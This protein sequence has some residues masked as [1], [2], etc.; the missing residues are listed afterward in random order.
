MALRL[1]SC[2]VKIAPVQSLPG[3]VDPS[4]AV[5]KKCSIAVEKKLKSKC[6]GSSTVDEK[7]LI[8]P[9]NISYLPVQMVSNKMTDFDSLLRNSVNHPCWAKIIDSDVIC[10][11]VPPTSVGS[12]VFCSPTKLSLSSDA[13][14]S[15][16][17]NSDSKSMDDRPSEE[18]LEIV[19][20]ILSKQMPNL[21]TEMIDYTVYRHDL[22]FENN[23]KGYR[24]VGILP[25]VKHLALVRLIGHLRF[26]YVKLELLKITRHPE[27]GTVKARWRIRGISGLKVMFMFWKIK[28]WKIKDTINNLDSWYDGFSTFHVGSDGKIFKHVVDKVMPENEENEKTTNTLGAKLALMFGLTAVPRLSLSEL[29][30]MLFKKSKNPPLAP[31]Q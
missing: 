24:T 6:I 10:S 30:S 13:D 31:I 17:I 1:R 8:F 4:S 27:D 25:Y 14:V 9:R 16:P 7:A 29:N 5:Q 26:A 20:N 3:L 28:L 18:Q 11:L 23:I 12:N 19:L 21:F 2:A 15:P 22:I